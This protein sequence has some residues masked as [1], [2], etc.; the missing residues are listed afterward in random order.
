MAAWLSKA[1]LWVSSLKEGI[2][3]EQTTLY[4]TNYCLSA[5]EWA[6]A[7]II[8]NTTWALQ[9]VP[10]A[11]SSHFFHYEYLL[12]NIRYFAVNFF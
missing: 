10:I 5:P 12:C 2:L 4:A 8:Q 11:L 7:R 3:T 6:E 9:L 1:F